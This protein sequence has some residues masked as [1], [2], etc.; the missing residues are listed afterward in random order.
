M[1]YYQLFYSIL[2]GIISSEREG[3]CQE[4]V[5]NVILLSYQEKEQLEKMAQ[6]YT[7]PYYSVIRA[8]IAL[9][10]AQGLSNDEIAAKV[11]MPRQT[12]SKWRK[13]FFEQRLAGLRD[14]PRTGRPARFSPRIMVAALTCEL[15]AQLGIPLSRFSS[16]E[17]RRHV[18][19]Q[20]IVASISRITIWRW[21]SE[22]AIK[23]WQYR[24]WIFPHDPD[25]CVKAA[26][27]LDLY[28]RVWNG[29]SL[30]ASDF[31]IS[32]DEKTV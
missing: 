24:S 12:V 26:P 28:Q 8:K 17:L 19:E 1:T 32:T 31:V 13:R 5:L 9:L 23:P 10:A 20:G 14:E 3:I 22:D 16:E 18:V 15:P 11:D 27:I 21:L 25:F 2:F 4:R 7:A 29:A 6:K 30:D